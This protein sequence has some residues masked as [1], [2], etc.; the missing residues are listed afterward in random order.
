MLKRD[1]CKSLTANVSCVLLSF[2]V[3]QLPRVHY[4]NFDKPSTSDQSMIFNE[5]I[6]DGSEQFPLLN[7]LYE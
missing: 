5:R 1:L 6:F 3:L 2:F 7:G 4:Y